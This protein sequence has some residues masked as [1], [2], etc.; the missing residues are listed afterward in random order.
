MKDYASNGASGSI[1]LRK[2]DN[3]EILLYK[4]VILFSRKKVSVHI[5]LQSFP[6][7]LLKKSQFFNQIFKALILGIFFAY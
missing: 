1:P 7:V 5:E 2:V 3:Y 4:N 6:L